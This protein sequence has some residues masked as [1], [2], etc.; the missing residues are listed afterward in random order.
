MLLLRWNEPVTQERLVKGRWMLL[1]L[2]ADDSGSQE[3][4]LLVVDH[5]RGPA[6]SLE[7]DGREAA[8]AAKGAG[9]SGAEAAE[10]A[11]ADNTGEVAAKE[12]AKTKG[13][14]I[15]ADVQDAKKVKHIDE[16]Q[17]TLAIELNIAAL[18]CLR[19]WP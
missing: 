18:T 5:H 19:V 14:I 10:A 13:E 17:T 6:T 11:A 16:Y 8:Q 12:A 2:E 9:G 7:L 15:P 3:V 1:L 4:A